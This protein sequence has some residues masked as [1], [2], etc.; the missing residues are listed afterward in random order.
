MHIL[1]RFEFGREK[2]ETRVV[3]GQGSRRRKLFP[4]IIKLISSGG[5]NILTLV[6]I[7]QFSPSHSVALQ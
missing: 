5:S 2:E 4:A 7:A 1:L 6:A 3:R